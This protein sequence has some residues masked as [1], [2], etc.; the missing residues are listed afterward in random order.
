MSRKSLALIWYFVPPFT[1]Y[2]DVEKKKRQKKSPKQFDKYQNNVALLHTQGH[3]VVNVCKCICCFTQECKSIWARNVTFSRQ[4]SCMY[5]E[6]LKWYSLTVKSP[7]L[8]IASLC[9]LLPVLTIFTGPTSCELRYVLT[10]LCNQLLHTT[11]NQ[12]SSAQ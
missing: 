10:I 2:L 3:I 4:V 7:K 11:Q 5:H 6:A 9:N 1:L 12:I 8:T